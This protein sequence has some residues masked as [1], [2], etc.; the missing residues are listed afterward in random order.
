MLHM[1]VSSTSDVPVFRQDLGFTNTQALEI[2]IIVKSLCGSHVKHV[3]HVD[4]EIERI[5]AEPQVVFG[6][7]IGKPQERCPLL[8]KF[9]TR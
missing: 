7:D 9:A 6:I 3:V 2:S 4:V 8:D 5:L 1:I